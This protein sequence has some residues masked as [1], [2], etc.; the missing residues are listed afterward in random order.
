MGSHR[1][2]STKLDGVPGTI[3][4]HYLWGNPIPV[5]VV[6]R[7]GRRPPGAAGTAP[8]HI[9]AHRHPRGLRE[10]QLRWGIA[11]EA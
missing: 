10:L 3:S 6:V 4:A 1:K 9:A 7:T 5:V 11:A 8:N 2:K